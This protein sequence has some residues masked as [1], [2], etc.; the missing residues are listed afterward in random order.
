MDNLSNDPPDEGNK[1]PPPQN[2]AQINSHYH[3]VQSELASHRF[4]D[5]HGRFIPQS[6]PSPTPPNFPDPPNPS[7]PSIP[8]ATPKM[9]SNFKKTLKFIVK[10]KWARVTVYIVGFI[11]VVNIIISLPVTRNWLE[12]N[13]P[14]SSPVFSREVSMQGILKSSSTGLYTLVLPDQQA[15]T[16]HFKPSSSLTN[17]KKLNEVVV[18]G[19][20]GWT[21]FV[22]ED[23]EIF[24]LNFTTDNTLDSSSKT[25]P[26]PQTSL[27]LSNPPVSP[28]PSNPAQLPDLYPLLSWETTQK[29][30]L[31]FTSGKRK[32]EQEGIY[33]ESSQNSSFPQDFINY[34]LTEFKNRGFKETLNSID[35]EGIT[36]TYSEDNLFLTFGIKNIYKGSGDQKQLAGYK[37]FIEHN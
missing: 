27:N 14:N 19:R 1:L 28:D 12:K 7:V 29:R 24:P 17:L 16:L 8:S 33:L 25:T 22:I 10:I 11:G 18:K 4:R 15:Y 31:I 20:L 9:E 32:I 36:I 13:F 30:T 6:S 3:I 23:A 5:A 35:P 21:P 2:P 26:A 34:Y 37:A